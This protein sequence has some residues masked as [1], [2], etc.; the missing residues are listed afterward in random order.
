MKGAVA[1]HLCL[2]YVM[3]PGFSVTMHSDEILCKYHPVFGCKAFQRPGFFR[4]W[5][6]NFRLFSKEGPGDL[7]NPSCR[8]TLQ[9][10]N[11]PATAL[12]RFPDHWGTTKWHNFSLPLLT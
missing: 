11:F 6:A 12:A 3:T 7:Y 9:R 8:E 10:G 2:N 5:P 4:L 1:H